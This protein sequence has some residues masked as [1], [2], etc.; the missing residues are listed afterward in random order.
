[1]EIFRFNVVPEQEIKRREKFKYALSHC[2]VCHGN[3]EFNYFDTLDEDKVE[4]V[5]HCKDC[6]RKAT[7]QLHS[8][9]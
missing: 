9:H 5:A 2:A 4:E 1:M 6:G 3:L 7:N 8:I